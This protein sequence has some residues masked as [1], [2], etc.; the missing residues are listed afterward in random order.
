MNILGKYNPFDNVLKVVDQAASILGYEENKYE[1][2]KYPERELKV[3]VPVIMDDGSLRVFEGFR[4]QHSTVRG[5]AK[6]GIRFHPDVDGDEVK[7]LA[8]WMSFKC[9]VVNIPYGGAKGGVVCNPRELSDDEY[10]RLTRRFTTAIAPLI[11]PEQDIPAPDVGSSAQTMAWM[12][13]TYSQ[14]KGHSVQGVVT[15]KPIG[16]GGIIGRS[17]ATGSGVMLTVRNIFNKL[18]IPIKGATAVVQGM[19]NVG[20]ISAQLLHNAGMKVV[21]VSDVS[22]GLY[23]E[24]GLNIPDIL[25]YLAQDKRNLLIDYKSAGLKQISNKELLGLEVTLLVP[26]ALENQINNDNADDIRAKVIVEAA[27]GPVTAEADEILNR[28]NV[29]VVPDI[30]ANAGGVVVSYFEWVQNIQAFC[31]SEEHVNTELKNI[32]DMAFEGVWD[33]AKENNTTLR[34][35]AYLIAVRRIVEASNVLGVWP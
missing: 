6:G 16:L 3:S 24:N 34:T 23:D 5:P 14:L 26:A 1:I 8:A 28:K 20:S 30:L 11:G 22:T 4:V 31:W 32:M 15:G 21:A 33:E 7:A 29:I 35:G 12:M 19:G 9:A 2:L 10:R 25:N 18:N 17:T 13:G 27:N